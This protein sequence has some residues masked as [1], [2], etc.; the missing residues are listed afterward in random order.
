MFNKILSKFEKVDLSFFDSKRIEKKELIKLLD[1]IEVP[2]QEFNKGVKLLRKFYLLKKNH[3]KIKYVNPLLIKRRV[4]Y[5]KDPILY[6][7]EVGVPNVEW[8]S[9]GSYCSIE[10]K[11][12]LRKE[13]LSHREV[14][15]DLSTIAL[16]SKVVQEELV[17]LNHNP[18]IDSYFYAILRADYIHQFTHRIQRNLE[19]N[20][21]YT[22]NSYKKSIYK[23][24]DEAIDLFK[25]Y[26]AYD[27]VALRD[28]LE[29]RKKLGGDDEY[30]KAVE[31]LEL[32]LITKDIIDFLKGFFEKREFTIWDLT[33][34]AK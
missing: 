10:K 25:R 19:K 30:L 22:A 3:E 26:R 12:K 13:D 28:A 7:V 27:V 20:Y 33:F 4:P 15:L 21:D 14:F 34:K 11:N 31:Q 9:K 17:D 2:I 8:T 23:D 6:G 16:Y 5:L 1:E 32:L 24:F 29:D 18:H